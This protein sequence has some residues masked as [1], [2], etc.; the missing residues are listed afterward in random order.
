MEAADNAA[1]DLASRSNVCHHLNGSDVVQDEVDGPRE[2]F[3]SL[4][5]LA[6]MLSTQV[7]DLSSLLALLRDEVR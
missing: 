2:P 7:T 6:F 3:E 4:R 1:E 5:P